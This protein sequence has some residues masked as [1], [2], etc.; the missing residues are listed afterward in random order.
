MPAAGL[1][2]ECPSTTLV[3]IVPL[4]VWVWCTRVDWLTVKSSS[5]KVFLQTRR[6]V[7]AGRERH[8]WLALVLL[9]ACGG[10]EGGPNASTAGA[11]LGSSA[12][13]Q[14]VQEAS[15]PGGLTPRSGASDASSVVAETGSRTDSCASNGNCMKG[16]YCKKSTCASTLG[17]CQAIPTYQDCVAA[18][19]LDAAVDMSMGVCACDSAQYAD[20]C[21]AAAVGV[22]VDPSGGC[23]NPCNMVQLPPEPP[24]PDCDGGTTSYIIS[25]ICPDPGGSCC[26][27][28]MIPTC[29]YPNVPSNPVVPD[30]QV[31]ATPPNCQPGG[32]G[33]SDCGS[34]KESCCA[35]EVVPGGTY[36][37][38]YDPVSMD[39]GSVVVEVASDGGPTGLAD[40]ATVSTFKL[41]KYD[42]TVGRFRQFVKAW[43]GGWLPTPGSGKH[44][45]LNGGLGLANVGNAA[46]YESGWLSSDNDKIDPTS[47][48]LTNCADFEGT[49]TLEPGL[50]ARFPDT[51]PITC[52]DWYEAQAFCIWDGGFLPSEAEW[53]YAAA[54]GDEQRKYP[55]G[56]IDPGFGN[57]SYAVYDC[58]YPY[59]G[60]CGGV[61]YVAPVGTAVL[62]AGR[63]DQLDL[64]GNVYQ[65][66][67]DSFAPYVDPCTDCANLTPTLLRV[68]RGGYFIGFQE[69]LLSALRYSDGSGAQSGTNGFRCARSPT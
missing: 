16:T 3:T 21:A 55:W 50:D 44:V 66:T 57:L 51:L 23:P 37:R 54:G 38:T 24:V 36:F 67:L 4:P 27:G 34:L 25:E 39:G 8:C 60:G 26:Q 28:V 68:K 18:A 32:P 20:R 14:S 64:A 13:S 53:E 43:G 42:V 47:D 1:G 58:D 41:D 22:N 6:T 35:T 61:I 46:T 29:F 12:P 65:W 59:P 10:R 15:T 9:L 17:I 19:G 48:S 31:A 5:D 2:K 69:T 62:G 7:L 63:W 11:G 33:L 49:W 30:A 56:S 40:P 45:H 52:V